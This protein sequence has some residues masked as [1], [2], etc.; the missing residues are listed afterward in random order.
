MTCLLLFY[1][2]IC[3]GVGTIVGFVRGRQ[4]ATKYCDEARIQVEAMKAKLDAKRAVV[5]TH[6]HDR[7]WFVEELKKRMVKR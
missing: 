6:V 7:R 4:K 3:F 1:G 2:F 5:K